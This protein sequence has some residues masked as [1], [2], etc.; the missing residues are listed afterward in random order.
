MHLTKSN[1]IH[2]NY[3]SPLHNKPPD[4]TRIT[5]FTWTRYLWITQECDRRLYAFSV[6]IVNSDGHNFE[7]FTLTSL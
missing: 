1:T 7:M 4:R 2:N 5:S 3:E 6:R